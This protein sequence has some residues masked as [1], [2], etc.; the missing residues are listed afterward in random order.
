VIG[1][2]R[3][4]PE[5]GPH[6]VAPAREIRFSNAGLLVVGDFGRPEGRDPATPAKL[7]SAGGAQVVDPLGIPAR[8]DEIA[9]TRELQDV[10]GHRAPL[11]A[12]PASHGK[13]GSDAKPHQHGI[14]DAADQPTGLQIALPATHGRLLG[15][16]LGRQL[17][18]DV[19]AMKPPNWGTIFAPL[20]V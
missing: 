20:Q 15:H 18:F 19:W 10:D 12:G 5:V 2:I 7:A 1:R 17:V 9:L 6:L 3:Q 11:P 16:S 14:D 4:S 13:R 8:R